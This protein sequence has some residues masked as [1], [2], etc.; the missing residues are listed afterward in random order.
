MNTLGPILLGLIAIVAIALIMALPVMWLWNST[1]PQLF[2]LQE[3][4]FGQALRL[5]LL[6]SFLFKSSNS[7]S[8][9]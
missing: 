7:T 8:K 1:I 5:S 2:K 9:N 6:C 4:D 3:I